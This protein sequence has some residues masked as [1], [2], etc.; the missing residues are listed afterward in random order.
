MKTMKTAL[1]L[2][3]LCVLLAL[4]AGCPAPG[5]A[6]AAGGPGVYVAGYYDNGP[7]YIACYWKDGLKTDLPGLDGGAASIS[8]SGGTVY[9]A[10]SLGD[11]VT[12]CYWTNTTRTDLPAGSDGGNA[13][14]ICVSS[15]TVYNAG[16]YSTPSYSF[17]CYWNNNS[18]VDITGGAIRGR[19]QGITVSGGLCTQLGILLPVLPTMP[20]VIGQILPGRF[21]PPAQ[22]AQE[23][24]TPFMYP[25]ARFIQPGIMTVAQVPSPVIGSIQ[26]RQTFR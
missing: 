23:M 2:T 17:P 9:T 18:L 13:S 16:Y 25:K 12:P 20:H 4:A 15:G 6:G 22:T 14:S 19:N 11:G 24:F 21:F 10:G 3:G 26:I 7:N 8:V 1:L 5:V